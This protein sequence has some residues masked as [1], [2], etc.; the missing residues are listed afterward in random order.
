MQPGKVSISIHSFTMQSSPAALDITTQ[1][2]FVEYE[3]F[4]F[5]HDDLE[6]PSQPLP[7]P[8]HSCVFESSHCKYH[9]VNCMSYMLSTAV[10]VHVCVCVS[11]AV[12]FH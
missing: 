12:Y 6:T 11:S 9:C 8:G 4:G 3:L 10:C 1:Y 7:L 5:H 2:M